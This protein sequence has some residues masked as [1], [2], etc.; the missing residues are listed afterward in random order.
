[1]IIICYF[2]GSDD[3]TVRLWDLRARRQVHSFKDNYQVLTV[4]FNEK[5]DQIFVSGIE[6]SIKVYDLRKKSIL[7]TL[8]EHSDSVT[9]LSL[10]PDGSHLLSNS[11]DNTRK[12]HLLPSNYCESQSTFFVFLFQFKFGMF[13]HMH[14]QIEMWP[15]FMDTYTTLKKICCAVHGVPEEIILPEDRPIALYT[16][17]TLKL[18]QSNTNCQAI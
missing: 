11:M 15:H 7:Y 16:C 18:D 8:D 17:G 12:I 14:H 9:G 5:A 3:K 1:M 6:N 13:G 4:A 10:S 2:S